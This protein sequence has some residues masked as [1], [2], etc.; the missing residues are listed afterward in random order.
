MSL[1]LRVA[2]GTMHGKATAVAPPFAKLGIDLV[3]PEDL[4]TDCFGTFT[5]EIPRAGT[6]IEAAR[7]KA[8]AASRLTGL[9]VGLASEGAYGPHP[10]IPFVPFGRE[11]LLWHEPASGRE[12]AEWLADEAPVYDQAIIEDVAATDLFLRNVRFPATALIV[13][14]AGCHGH[15]VAK[16]VTDVESLASAVAS[17]CAISPDGRA[18]VQTDMRAHLN[19]RRMDTIRR[20]AERLSALLAGDCPSCGEHGWGRLRSVAG[21]P[22]CWC[23]GPTPLA[24]ADI[25]GCTACGHETEQIRADDPTE[26]DPAQCPRC[27]P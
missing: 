8:R 11:L 3:V 23:G 13:A 4:D 17:A 22:C 1:P 24:R 27:N 19:P 20:L 15:P 14:P 12:I 6:M 5:G 2:F 18:L 16:G 21:L 25:L 26:A 9:P 10:A 7:A